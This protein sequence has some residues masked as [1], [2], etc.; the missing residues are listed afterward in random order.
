MSG[1]KREIFS[2]WSYEQALVWM[3]Q[4]HE[5]VSTN[6]KTII[7]ACGSHSE[8]I[9]TL[10]RTIR[11]PDH[12][13]QSI[14]KILN[15]KIHKLDRGGGITAH[16]PG[17]LVLYP[18]L[19]LVFH[20]LSI[21]DLIHLSEEV[22]IKFMAHFGV[23]GRRSKT[24]AGIFVKDA[25]IGFIGLRIKEGISTHGL[26]LNVFNDAQVFSHF[27]PCGI[28]NLAITSLHRHAHIHQNLNYCLKHLS[29]VF[30]NE[31]SQILSA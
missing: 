24:G 22:I 5:Q 4:A 25:K 19:N 6:S 15:I 30:V 7:V 27:A 17:Q 2:V 29:F 26:A 21:P 14:A 9:I 1:I 23:S 10:G 3:H 16:E 20:R 13:L 18:I 11:E 31:L 12:K 8:K 28:P